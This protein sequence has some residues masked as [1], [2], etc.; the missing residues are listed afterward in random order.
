MCHSGYHIFSGGELLT[1][2]LQPSDDLT[3]YPEQ[4]QH[5]FIANDVGDT[6]K[7]R[8]ILLTVCGIPT[9]KVKDGKLVKDVKLDST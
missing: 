5:Y 8:S 3:T 6:G 9:Y 4:L 1:E 7:K 2:L